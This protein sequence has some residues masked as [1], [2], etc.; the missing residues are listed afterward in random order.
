MLHIIFVSKCK[1]T[2]DN[3][4]RSYLPNNYTHI[5]SSLR[6]NFTTRNIYTYAFACNIC[7]APSH[8][9]MC[10]FKR[11]TRMRVGGR[12]PGVLLLLRR[13]A[14]LDS[15][16][17]NIRSIAPQQPWLTSRIGQHTKQTNTL[18]KYALSNRLPF[19]K[20]NILG[21]QRPKAQP[22]KSAEVW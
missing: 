22:T 15:L 9:H 18:Q 21:S 14:S 12:P 8:T 2:I 13:A 7:S 11:P 1:S 19:V 16:Y 3:V 4:G 10:K 5:V 20:C 6:H 17:M